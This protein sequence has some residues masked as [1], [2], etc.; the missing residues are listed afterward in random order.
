MADSDDLCINGQFALERWGNYNRDRIQ[1]YSSENLIYKMRHGSGHFPRVGETQA[2]KDVERT[3]HAIVR[4]L[5]TATLVARCLI[6]KY[7]ED[8]K[9]ER[10][11]ARQMELSYSDFREKVKVGNYMIG[12][13]LTTE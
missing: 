12:L 1:G 8:R 11:L 2:P 9:G 4:L 10:Q 6:V 3:E 13:I 7:T 5:K